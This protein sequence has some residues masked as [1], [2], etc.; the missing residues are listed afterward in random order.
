[1]LNGVC[2]FICFSLA[3]NVLIKQEVLLTPKKKWKGK[4]TLLLV[5][6]LIALGVF[7]TWIVFRKLGYIHPSGSNSQ[8]IYQQTESEQ[9]KKELPQSTP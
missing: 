5:I 1:M 8:Q 6:P 9:I 4:S 2:A 3:L 7:M